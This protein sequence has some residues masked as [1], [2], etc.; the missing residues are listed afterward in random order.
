M[1]G[2]PFPPVE[3][4]LPQRGRMMLLSA[5]LEHSDDRTVC[6]ASVRSDSPFVDDDD[7]MPPV[8]GLEYLAQCVAAHAGLRGWS[9]GEPPRVGFLIGARRLDFRS[10]AR[11]RVGQRLTV[12]ASRTWGEEEFA[13]FA[14]RLH[15]AGARALLLEGSLNVFL[16]RSLDRF[17]VAPPA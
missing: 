1:M 11:L 12:E 17:A 5:V 8:I 14:C 9:R 7:T 3:A 13:M 4:I 16:P 10:G 2:G 6:T 15:D